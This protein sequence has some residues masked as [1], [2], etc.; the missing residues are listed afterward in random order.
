MLSYL[1]SLVAMNLPKS[2]SKRTQASYL[3]LE[4]KLTRQAQQEPRLRKYLPFA[5]KEAVRRFNDAISKGIEPVLDIY[6]PKAPARNPITLEIRTRKREK[7]RSMGGP[8]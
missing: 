1:L 3:L 7:D 8:Q 5:R 6:D 4:E 2:W